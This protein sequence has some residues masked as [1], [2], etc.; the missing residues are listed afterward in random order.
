L[1]NHKSAEKRARQ[2]TRKNARNSSTKKGVRTWEKNLRAAILK[3]DPKAAQDLLG[4][5]MSKVGK[6]VAKGIV[7]A[8][9]GARKVSRLSSLLSESLGNK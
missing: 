5:Y 2:S 7:N 6:A 9:T 8:R 4:T 3:K 1:A